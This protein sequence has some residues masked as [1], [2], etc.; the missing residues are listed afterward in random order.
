MFLIAMLVITMQKV[1][2]AMLLIKGINIDG[3]IWGTEWSEPMLADTV[4]R[5]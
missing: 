5:I 2:I 3:G 4:T 1:L